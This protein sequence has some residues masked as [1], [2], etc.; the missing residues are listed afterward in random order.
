MNDPLRILIEVTA[1]PDVL[2][3]TFNRQLEGLGMSFRSPGEAVDC[4]LAREVLAVPGVIAV[5]LLGNFLTV[6]K[7]PPADWQA[8]G[9]AIQAKIFRVLGGTKCNE[10]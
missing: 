2:K 6:R 3:V 7:E 10:K 4:P 1:D 8:I 5:F 9:P